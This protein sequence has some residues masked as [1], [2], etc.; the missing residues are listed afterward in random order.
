MEEA[1][2]CKHSKPTTPHIKI[3]GR[4]LATSCLLNGSTYTQAANFLHMCNIDTVAES[5]FYEAQLAV[6]EPIIEAAAKTVTRAREEVMAMT[7]PRLCDDSRWDSARNGSHNTVAAIETTSGK[8]V[9]YRNTIKYGGKRVGNYTGPSNMMESEGLKHV[10]SDVKEMFG[11]DEVEIT[12]DGDNKST[13]IFREAGLNF[14]QSH[15]KGHGLAAIKR[16]F[17]RMKEVV[18][19]QLNITTPFYGI[20]GRLIQYAQYL[21]NHEP[22]PEKRVRLWLNSPSHYVGDHSH[23]EHPSNEK[24][25]GRPRK[26][27]IKEKSEDRFY[28]W[29]KGV[30]N[31]ELKEI[32]EH[33]CESTAHII[34]SCVSTTGTNQCEAL[35][36]MI[37]KYAPKRISF[38][39]SY[40]ARAA[41]AVGM[42]NDPTGFISDVLE[43]TGVINELSPKMVSKI[44][45]KY[46][47]QE[48]LNS[49]RR[50]P[51]E[52]NRIDQ[53]R[54]HIRQIYG[55]QKTGDY[56]KIEN[57]TKD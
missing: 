27:P 32:L 57:Q 3:P 52:R 51:Y 24:K 12:T 15:D 47:Q 50:T 34:E 7:K 37:G 5:T 2:M 33:F 29:K 54:Y 40:E 38:G 4:V 49:F 14:T 8:V 1:Q 23:C 53:T 10:I 42:K 35:N 30:E 19:E 18:K 26:K 56:V 31:S 17:S 43:A 45:R 6:E 11:D 9:S 36:S 25:V 21:I 48:D 22:N 44:E 46:A 20:E 13:R 41:I 39:N 16:R 28:V 55:S